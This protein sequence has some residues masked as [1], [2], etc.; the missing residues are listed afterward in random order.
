MEMVSQH[1]TVQ[2]SIHV[3]L[4]QQTDKP[5]NVSHAVTY[6]T[7]TAFGRRPQAKTVNARILGNFGC[8][9]CLQSFMRLFSG[10]DNSLRLTDP[11]TVIFCL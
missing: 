3:P 2:C 4:A 9:Q 8:R 1:S 11:D 10:M 6:P 5:F 7:L